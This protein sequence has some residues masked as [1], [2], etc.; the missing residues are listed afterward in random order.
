MATKITRGALLNNHNRFACLFFFYVKW[1]LKTTHCIQTGLIYDLKTSFSPN[2][3][4]T[5][6]NNETY[7]HI[8][9][10]THKDDD[11]TKLKK[12]PEPIRGAKLIKENFSNKIEPNTHWYA[13]EFV[14]FFFCIHI[15]KLNWNEFQ[16]A[17]DHKKCE[18]FNLHTSHN[19][20]YTPAT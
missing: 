11:R 13:C 19:T 17:T 16:F 1:A 18:H 7:T 5:F 20:I 8:W 12:K 6:A 4:S 10:P 9:F 14:F 3:N 2:D 15:V